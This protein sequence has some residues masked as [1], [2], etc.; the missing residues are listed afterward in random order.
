MEE[1]QRKLYKD[2]RDALLPSIKEN[3]RITE[4]HW[5]KAFRDGQAAFVVDAK[6]DPKPMW[7]FVMPPGKS[8]LPMLEFALVYA[9]SDREQLETSL[10]KYHKVSEEMLAK[11]KEEFGKHQEEFSELFQGPAAMLP[12][13][14]QSAEVPHPTE[15]EIEGGKIRYPATL[16]Q[17]GIDSALAPS[18]GWSSDAYV[19]TLSPQ[20]AE[21]L[22]GS[23]EIEG[24]L[25]KAKNSRLAAASFVDVARLVGFFRPWI[26]YGMDLA[27]TKGEKELVEQYASQVDRVLEIMQC[28]RQYYSITMEGEQSLVT[29]YRSDFKDLD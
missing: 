25:A 3:Q 14:I 21:R 10:E 28:Y 6:L 11:L 12:G 8:P 15:K 20:T 23:T 19:L 26:A 16:Q 29:H 24:P 1:K 17:L 22:L 27:A 7:H 2:F 9:L 13:M 4:E 18:M 5:D